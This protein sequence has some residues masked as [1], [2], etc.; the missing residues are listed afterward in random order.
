MSESPLYERIR[1]DLLAQIQRGEFTPNEPFVTQRSLREKYKVSSTTAI[2]V[3]T[4]MAAEGYLERRRGLGSFVRTPEDA[5]R[6]AGTT[7]QTVIYVG[8]AQGTFHAAL[9]DGI[10]SAATA[11][12]MTLE[13]ARA[14][15]T[16]AEQAQVLAEAAESGAAGIILYPVDGPP[17]ETLA[18]TL[19]RHGDAPLVVVD[20]FFPTIPTDAVVADNFGIGRSLTTLLLSAGHENIACLW[21]EVDCTSVRDRQAGHRDA[22][23]DY[24]RGQHPDLFVLRPYFTLPKPERIRILKGF[25]ERT[26]PVTAFLCSNA[27]VAAQAAADL[28]ELGIG[29]PDDVDLA[30]MDSMGPYDVLP[31]ARFSARVDAAA[32]GVHAVTAALTR[33]R[34]PKSIPAQ[35]V[36]PAVIESHDHADAYLAVRSRSHPGRG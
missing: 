13:L 29:V 33:A 24:G 25:L 4:T 12:S 23:A 11:R 6:P 31:L 2:R 27:Y 26:D 20:R 32:I 15:Q 19:L 16:A 3:L 8:H 18:R 5:R 14:G 9:L 28:A 22:L 10:R 1:T 30:S 7:R 21:Q 34:A 36:V 17:D 35:I